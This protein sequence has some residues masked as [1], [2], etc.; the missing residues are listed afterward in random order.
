MKEFI[1]DVSNRKNVKRK[2][3]LEKDILIHKILLDLSKDDFFYFKE[4]CW[5]SSRY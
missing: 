5:L 3:L 4:K 2:D 1:E